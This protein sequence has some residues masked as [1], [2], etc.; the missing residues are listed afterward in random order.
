MNAIEALGTGIIRERPVTVPVD[1]KFD[2]LP[3]AHGKA[4]TLFEGIGFSDSEVGD[5][6]D[7]FPGGITE[8][9]PTG[10]YGD[11]RF[12]PTETEDGS[13][14]GGGMEGGVHLG[15]TVGKGFE[16]RPFTIDANFRVQSDAHIAR[17][18]VHFPDHT[19]GNK[20]KRFPFIRHQTDAGQLS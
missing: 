20:A 3:A 18:V 19:V 15:Q 11:S 1:G 5:A 14:G 16:V 17:K 6:Q 2:L 7:D 8:R 12:K 9:Y 10:R 4:V 13:S